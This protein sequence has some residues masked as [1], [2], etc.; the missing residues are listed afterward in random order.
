MS[1]SKTR[2]KWR[3]RVLAGM[4]AVLA[5]GTLSLAAPTQRSSA[6]AVPSSR[7]PMS[8]IARLTAVALRLASLDG[9]ARPTSVT[10]VV[11]SHGRA[12][13]AATPGDTLPGAAQ[14]VYL[15]VMKGNFTLNVPTPPGDPEPTGTYLSIT[16]DP[17]TFQLM[18]LGLSHN[19]PP[20]SLRSFGRVST[21]RGPS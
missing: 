3:R 21:L 11:T 19:A 16:L 20:I 10:A 5:V 15:V 6:T 9:D 1:D 7:I 2:E 12:L 17:A 13:R 18:D 8:A 14:L 4:A